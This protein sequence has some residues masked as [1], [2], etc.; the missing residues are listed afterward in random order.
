MRQMRKSTAP[1][2]K[3]PTG[4]V[5]LYCMKSMRPSS[6][7]R[8]HNLMKLYSYLIGCW[9]L[10]YVAVSF[11]TWLLSNVHRK[12]LCVRHDKSAN[13]Y[14]GMSSLAKGQWCNR[15]LS[16]IL[17]SMFCLSCMSTLTVRRTTCLTNHI[18][19]CL[20]TKVYPHFD[21]LYHDKYLINR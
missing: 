11:G 20:T 8:K 18:S 6:P 10:Q 5:D 9:L 21:W 16:L 17:L 14:Q 3:Y 12:K 7:V 1:D 4:W 19:N 15:V 2:G 13:L